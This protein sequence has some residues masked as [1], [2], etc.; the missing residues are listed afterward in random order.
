MPLLRVLTFLI[1]CVIFCARLYVKYDAQL[2]STVHTLPPKSLHTPISVYA[3]KHACYSGL[4]EGQ[5]EGRHLCKLGA[6]LKK[7]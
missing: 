1:S 6:F 7:L 2:H 3:I 4:G 5:G